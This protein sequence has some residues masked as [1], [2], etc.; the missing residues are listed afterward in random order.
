M[1]TI[2]VL[3][4]FGWRCVSKAAPSDPREMRE[5]AKNVAR[6]NPDFLATEWDGDGQHF[7]VNDQAEIIEL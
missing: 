2:K 1:K 5:F 6:R 7:F 3:V 4:Y